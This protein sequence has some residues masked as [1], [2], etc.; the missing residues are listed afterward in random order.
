MVQYLLP[1]DE[2]AVADFL[3]KNTAAEGVLHTLHLVVPNHYSVLTQKIFYF[4]F[5]HV[6]F[7]LTL[8]LN[9]LML[10]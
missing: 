9:C 5:S 10:Q 4:K 1:D 3:D 2:H 6:L 8:D 7:Y